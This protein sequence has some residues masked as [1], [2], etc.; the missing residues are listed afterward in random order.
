[1]A[2]TTPALHAI[3][4]GLELAPEA[5]GYANTVLQAEG[6]DPLQAFNDTEVQ[7]HHFAVAYDFLRDVSTL[8]TLASLAFTD[9]HFGTTFL[10]KATA[11]QDLQAIAQDFD[12]SVNRLHCYLPSVCRY[13][14]DLRQLDPQK[15]RSE[16]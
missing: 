9:R 3:E 12:S 7:R 13:V 4:Q 10:Q 15:N 8:Q 6:I 2:I 1:M 16:T 14:I 5:Y 11:D